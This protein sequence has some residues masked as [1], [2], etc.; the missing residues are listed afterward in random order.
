MYA[1]VCWRC[2]A[3]L[4]TVCLL[5]C[6]SNGLF[7]TLHR[8][9]DDNNNGGHFVPVPVHHSRE[10]LLSFEKLPSSSVAP[11][12]DINWTEYTQKKKNHTKK[13]RG[14]RG[15]IRNRLRRRGIR[16]PLPT[17]SL[18]NARSLVKKMDE[19]TALVRHDGDYRRCNLFCVTE[20]WLSDEK[21]IGE[22]EG[23]TAIRLDR[24]N[25]K[26]EKELGGGLLMFVSKNWATNYTVR[27]TCSTKDFE[28]L[29]V[30]FRPHYLPREF[31][32]LTVILVYVPGPNNALAADRIAECYN[33][34]LCRASDQPVMLLGDFNTCD[35]SK[36]LPHLHQ[37]VTHPTRRHNILDKC[38]LNVP[39]AYV[40]RVA[41]PLGR[42]DHNVVHLLPS[43]RQLVKRERPHTRVIRQWDADST[44]ALRGCFD[45]TD[46]DVFFQNETDNDRL[47]DSITSYIQFCENNVVNKKQVRVY[48]NN[49]PWITK[50]LKQCLN[51][52]K[53]AFLAGDEQKVRELEKEF[54]KK[55][56]VVKLEYKNKV[57][58]KFVGGNVRDAWKGLNVMMGRGEQHKPIHGDD[59]VT[60]ANDL[61]SFYARF[62]VHDFKK[63]CNDLCVP[64]MS[65]PNDVTVSESDVTV[66]FS[67]I[68][69]RKAAGPDGL[70]GR[71]LKQCSVQLS[72]VFTRLFQL[73][74]DMHFVPR[75][76]RTSTIVP[77]PKKPNARDLNDFR[78]VALTSILCKCMERVV[79]NR[80]TT[81]VADRMDPLQ[82]AYRVGRGVEDATATLLDLIL[83]HL[84][85]PK[86][87]SRV[88]FMDFS[89]AF[90][91]L[92]PHL[93]ISRLLD[94]Q[95][96]PSVVLWI[97]AFLCDRPQRVSVGGSLSEEL[98]LN[99]GAPQGCVLSPV[100][101]S[102]YTNE[103]TCNTSILTLVKFAD[104]MALV[105]RLTD[106]H[107]L[108]QYFMYIESLSSWF[109]SSFLELN[110]KKT[111]ELCFEEGR[112]RDTSLVRPVFINNEPVEQVDSFKYL[113]T[114]L[115]KKLSFSFH[116][117]NVCKKANQRLYLLR[118]LKC[119]DVR[120]EILETVYR[121]LVES[122]LTFNIIVWFGNLTV[123]D[124]ARLSRV[125]KLAGKIIGSEQRQLSH[126]YNMFL[127]RKAQ[128][129]RLDPTHPL[130]NSFQMLPSGRRLRTPLAKRNL[131]KHSFIPSA[132]SILNSNSVS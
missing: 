23:Y 26:T 2:F 24:D 40:D 25:K 90:N 95:V 94:L 53:V 79:C 64:L 59:P 74:L 111:K 9:G 84:D 48:A 37:Y 31:G 51:D 96:S 42:S 73:L 117:D 112:A 41:P 82:F 103:L 109:D 124:R 71:V 88:L 63:E 49:K 6:S 7:P 78:P 5:V 87:F 76:W 99:T 62:D 118:K 45:S 116:V 66:C 127:K 55:S 46:W 33:R 61:N 16:L 75:I 22:L 27:E 108:S 104:D 91:T 10:Y 98:V 67:R 32:Q 102:I 47:T 69:P 101:F 80:L 130:H 14:S 8:F 93:L 68:N 56:R 70:G 17:V 1:K 13:K 20:T 52:K 132:I 72:H 121:S 4:L 126:L 50:D 86:T 12:I 15:G 54:R 92:Q 18:T 131:Y 30:S 44:E 36:H 34:A 28:L 115:D 29:S 38:Y 89:S 106:E 125:V 85:K 129:I 43:Y 19:L 119:F 65:M 11:C 120:S 128:K 35:V 60:F 81:T 57:E 113:G 105:A 83:N 110:V 58:E 77:V 107:S 114:V 3:V 122:I 123:K 39:D 21:D 97:R 100:L